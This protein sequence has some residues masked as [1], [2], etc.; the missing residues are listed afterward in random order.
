MLATR[1]ITKPDHL[2]SI[3]RKEN[4]VLMPIAR[5]LCPLGSKELWRGL[6]TT[7]GKKKQNEHDTHAR[8]LPQRR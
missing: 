4:S 1:G 5:N 7:G 8:R 6:G 2:H 3:F